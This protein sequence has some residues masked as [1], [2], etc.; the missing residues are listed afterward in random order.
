[1]H[2]FMG[3]DT[4]ES[5]AFSVAQ[6]S[7]RVQSQNG[8]FVPMSALHLPTLGESG[9]YTRPTSY[10]D[11][12]LWDD[13]SGAYMSTEHAN[14]RFLVPHL[15]KKGW[16]LF[17]DCD[18]ILRRPI[19]DIMEQAI[20]KYAVMVVKH[21][22]APAEGKKMDGQ[23]QQPY[24][25][26]NWSSVI[27]W[28]L[29]HASNRDLTLEMVNTL[30][31]RELHRFCWLKGYEIGELTPDWNWLVGHSDPT[32]APAIVHYTEGL[33]SMAGYENCAFADEWRA[34]RSQWLGL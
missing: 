6:Y 32:I 14:S 18:I 12:R 17:T 2:Y 25:R 11:G 33:P 19:Q 34:V 24:F 5:E 7:A 23:L 13:I 15:A 29:D 31:G 8:W 28:N 21:N 10:K 1:M 16:A 9:L 3:Y 30:P 27:L 26:K 22:Y 20:D 4:K